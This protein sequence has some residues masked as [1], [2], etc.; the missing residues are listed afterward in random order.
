MR[1]LVVLLLLCASALLAGPG[2][3]ADYAE[4]SARVAAAKKGMETAE[5]TIAQAQGKLQKAIDKVMQAERFEGPHWAELEQAMKAWSETVEKQ[6]AV[7]DG[8]ARTLLKLAP[9]SSL[10]AAQLETPAFKPLLKQMEGIARD[11]QASIDR[12][13][14][15]KRR[16]QQLEAQTQA[17]IGDAAKGKVADIALDAIGVPTDAADLV[18]SLAGGAIGAV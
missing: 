2:L 14:A 9:S 8:H 17:D 15:M 18:A 3:A 10:P 11:L 5:Q 4:I 1:R 7:M 12:A 13:E 6:A 16:Y